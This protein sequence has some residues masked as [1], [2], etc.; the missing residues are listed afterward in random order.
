VQFAR[1]HDDMGMMPTPR[2]GAT[3]LAAVMFG[4]VACASNGSSGA[5]VLFN[6]Q[7]L[8]SQQI[9][10]AGSYIAAYNAVDAPGCFYALDL[11]S[12]AGVMVA[13]TKVQAP[14]G[15]TMVTPGPDAPPPPSVDELSPGLTGSVGVELAQPGRW[16][17]RASGPTV[18]RWRV[19]LMP[20][21]RPT[22]P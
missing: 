18:C 13:I 1:L 19:T 14:A 6:S 3:L 10:S 17:V 11:V 7:G 16:S 4:L 5:G 12:D 2:L 8:T 22:G 9:S 15:A 20:G 21:D